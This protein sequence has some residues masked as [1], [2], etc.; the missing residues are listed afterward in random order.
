M[1]DPSRRW[2]WLWASLGLDS[3]RYLISGLFVTV[4]GT[5]A[6][7][8]LLSVLPYPA[9]FTIVFMASICANV[10]LQSKFVFRR[11]VRDRG[12]LLLT[13]LLLQYLIGLG[14]LHLMLDILLVDRHIAPAINLLICTPINFLLSRAVFYQKVSNAKETG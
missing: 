13:V 2:R 1:I 3:V 11:S 7:T 4:T 9:A 6:L 12:K 14:L 5:V 10:F 8:L